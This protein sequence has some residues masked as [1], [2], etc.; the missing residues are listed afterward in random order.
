MV[1]LQRTILA[2]FE[3]ARE[4][5]WSDTCGANEV[6]FAQWL[7]YM[8]EAEYAFLRARGLS[9]VLQ[10][11]RGMIGFP[12]LAC[13]LNILGSAACGQM[14]MT[15]LTLGH[16]DG[17]QLEYRFGIFRDDQLLAQGRFLVAC[18]RFPTDRPPYAIPIPDWVLQKL[19]EIVPRV[20]GERGASAP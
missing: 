16:C 18:C 4:V 12:R 13:E 8:E 2:E 7:C 17:K 1:G 3:H 6:H 5:R 10:D 11:C 9:V 14:L 15:R 19:P 20:L